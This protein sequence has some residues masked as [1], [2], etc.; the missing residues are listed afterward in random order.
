MHIVLNEKLVTLQFDEFRRM[1]KP[2]KLWSL[3]QTSMRNGKTPGKLFH[4]ILCDIEP[5]DFKWLC[6]THF[7]LATTY[8]QASDRREIK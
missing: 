6:D 4:S 5:A 1:R 3:E 7:L 2:K 8:E